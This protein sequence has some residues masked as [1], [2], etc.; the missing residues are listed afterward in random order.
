M[1]NKWFHSFNGI[2]WDANLLLATTTIQ[3]SNHFNLLLVIKWKKTSPK[4]TQQKHNQSIESNLNNL[5]KFIWIV[6]LFVS[7]FCLFI[8]F[9]KKAVLFQ[10]PYVKKQAAHPTLLK[11]ISAPSF[12]S[13]HSWKTQSAYKFWHKPRSPKDRI[14]S[15]FSSY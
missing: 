8:F 3:N 15:Q 4:L 1:N 5:P 12:T 14:W 11:Y 6:I 13:L 2:H 9:F 7:Y 10:T